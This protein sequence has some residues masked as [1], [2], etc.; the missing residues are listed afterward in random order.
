MIKIEYPEHRYKIELRDNREMIFDIVR[1]LWVNLTPEEWV[2]QNFLQYLIEVKQYPP[3]LISV[4]KEIYLGELKKRC[5]IVIYNRTGKPYLMV[6]CKAMDVDLSTK[7][8]DQVLRYNIS[9]PVNYLIITNGSYCFAFERANEKFA[10]L[11]DIPLW[12]D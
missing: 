8:I 2:R 5:D 7:T 9:I 11:Y 1:K 3:S 12:K 6:E 4:E 10:E